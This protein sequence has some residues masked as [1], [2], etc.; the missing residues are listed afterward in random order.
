[1]LIAYWSHPSLAAV[2]RI[3]LGIVGMV[4]I[5]LVLLFE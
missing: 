4:V 2:V 3:V 5:A 1:M